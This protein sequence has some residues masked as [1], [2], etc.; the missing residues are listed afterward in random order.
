MQSQ[1]PV[2]AVPPDRLIQADELA[3][4]VEWRRRRLDSIDRFVGSGVHYGAARSDASL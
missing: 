4:G 3:M 1:G 2:V